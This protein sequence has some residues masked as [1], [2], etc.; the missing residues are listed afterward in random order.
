MSVKQVG[1]QVLQAWQ[2]QLGRAKDI[3]VRT[4][5]RL[6]RDGMKVIR[7]LPGSFMFLELM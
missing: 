5:V 3:I 6:D 2:A 4:A 7:V 1:S